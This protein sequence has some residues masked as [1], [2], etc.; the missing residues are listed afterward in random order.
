MENMT[1]FP[2]MILTCYSQATMQ[3]TLACIAATVV[4]A[5][6]LLLYKTLKIFFDKMKFIGWE[7]A[8]NNYYK[9]RDEWEKMEGN[10]EV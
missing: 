8:C 9:L 3:I 10:A 7:D 6:I 2:I 1:F 5:K 4:T